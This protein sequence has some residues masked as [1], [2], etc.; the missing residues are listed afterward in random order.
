[1]VDLLDPGGEQL[2]EL[3][4]CCGLLAGGQLDQEL[5]T[6]SPEETLDFSPARGLPGL[7]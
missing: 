4:Q 3:G 2:V 5:V 1:V 6:D 7:L